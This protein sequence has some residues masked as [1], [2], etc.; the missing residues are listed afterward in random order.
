MGY[1][2]N[3]GTGMGGSDIEQNYFSDNTGGVGTSVS[4]G[5]ANKYV[6]MGHSVGTGEG[7]VEKACAHCGHTNYEGMDYCE[8][9]GESLN[10]DY[11]IYN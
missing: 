9:C 6:P 7:S 10:D 4:Y 1:G 3:T 5:P 11:D 8:K 2:I